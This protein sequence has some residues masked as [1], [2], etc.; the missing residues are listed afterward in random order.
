MRIKF[1]IMNRRIILAI[2]AAT[3][4]IGVDAQN[5]WEAPNSNKQTE[6]VVTEEKTEKKSNGKTEDAQYLRGRV[7]EK[8]GKVV[9]TFNEKAEGSDAEALYAKTYEWI[10]KMTE[11][12][13]QINSRIALVNKGEHKIVA[14]FSE[15]L[16]FSRTFISVDRSRLDYVMT[17]EC[18]DGEVNIEISR[19]R[20]HYD[21]DRPTRMNVTAEEWISDSKALNKNGTKIVRGRK[22]FRKHTIDRMNE[23]D[24][25][26]KIAIRL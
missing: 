21:E 5:T 22:K 24:N 3:A 14:T 11:G 16:D 12:E 25:S 8:D 7:P 10:E 26:L 9:F 18:K 13:N 17:A 15:W 19:I 23:I 20:F 4:A 6:A 2:I 1:S